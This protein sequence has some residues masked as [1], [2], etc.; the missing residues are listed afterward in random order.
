MKKI[1]IALVIT[2]MP[3]CLSAVSSYINEYNVPVGI[4][5]PYYNG[6]NPIAKHI[7]IVLQPGDL[8]KGKAGKNGYVYEQYGLMPRLAEELIKNNSTN[9]IVS[10]GLDRRSEDEEYNNFINGLTSENM[11][12]WW[13]TSYKDKYFKERAGAEKEMEKNADKTNSA[14]LYYANLELQKKYYGQA[15][16]LYSF[17]TNVQNRIDD[18]SDP[19]SDPDKDGLDNRTEYYSGS[20]PW[21]ESGIVCFPKYLQ[22]IPDGGQMVTG[23]FYIANRS[24]SNLFC[25]FENEFISRQDNRY[26]PYLFD[27]RGKSVDRGMNVPGQSTNKV[28]CLIKEEFF[29]RCFY[30]SYNISISVTNNPI[31]T[32][33]IY[34]PGNYS[35]PLQKPTNL[36]PKAGYCIEPGERV[37]CSWKDEWNNK[38]QPNQTPNDYKLQVIGLKKRFPLS[39][40]IEEKKPI[41]L[42]DKD[43]W[44]YHRPEPGNYIW[45][46]NKQTRFSNPVSSDWSWFNIGREVA[47]QKAR[48]YGSDEARVFGRNEA[49]VI[50]A[51]VG[52]KYDLPIQMHS[53]SN[54][55]FLK[56]LLKNQEV[57]YKTN[58]NSFYVAGVFEKTGVYSNM[59]LNINKKSGTNEHLYV[60]IVRNPSEDKNVRSFY[61]LEDKTIV[62]ELFVN[63]PFEYKERQFFETFSKKK[64]LIWNGD[65]KMEFGEALPEGLSV[66]RTEDGE[67]LEIKGI[68]STAG[69]FKIDLAF[70][71]GKRH[72]KEQHVFRIKDI[73][74][75][76]FEFEKRLYVPKKKRKRTDFLIVEGKNIVNHYSYVGIDFKYPIYCETYPRYNWVDDYWRFVRDVKIKVIGDPA[77]GLKVGDI[78]F[79]T[80]F[81]TNAETTALGFFGKPT[82]A[83]KFTNM[84]VLAEKDLVI[85]NEHIFSIKQDLD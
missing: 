29:P 39:F 8:Y 77:P 69:T 5:V 23:C 78:P 28:F 44:L 71:N 82:Q 14:N 30:G 79:C 35:H 56:P 27:E 49:R 75:P 1:I 76:P 37:L 12:D 72:A 11:P 34:T 83:G 52:E 32:I 33:N 68:P 58:F 84:V 3:V 70:S 57:Y 45:R 15:V 42:I 48:V 62:H 80:N 16:R 26:R 63:V 67:D 24:Q 81:V 54:S 4:R 9:V 85:T 46:V 65:L 17:L 40:S 55:R 31:G 22:I 43:D 19:N 64:D 53:A 18:L 2:T 6:K 10:W 73:G 25:D 51:T 47:P 59:W 13:I 60:F 20:N 21:K 36:S 61:Y 7:D 41:L 50:T 66:S 74:E 38:N